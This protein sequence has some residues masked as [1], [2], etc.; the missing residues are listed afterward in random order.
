MLLLHLPQLPHGDSGA[1]FFEIDVTY[2]PHVERPTPRQL[3]QLV[4]KAIHLCNERAA[5]AVRKLREVQEQHAELQNQMPSITR[6]TTCD[7]PCMRKSSRC[8]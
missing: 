3:P 2:A 1:P 8:T 6:K 7:S 5:V 4:D